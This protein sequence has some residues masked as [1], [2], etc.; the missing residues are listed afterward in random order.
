MQHLYTHV[1][2]H[3]Q[4]MHPNVL[5]AITHTRTHTHYSLHT[6]PPTLLGWVFVATVPMAPSAGSTFRKMTAPFTA[7]L[8]LAI[9]QRRIALLMN[10][11]CPRCAWCVYGVVGVDVCGCGCRVARV[12]GWPQ[13]WMICHTMQNIMLP[14]A[15]R[16]SQKKT[17]LMRPLRFPPLH[18]HHHHP[19]PP[20]NT[21]F[22]LSKN[23][24]G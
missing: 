13:A 16:W 4:R 18:H 2:M 15:H 5:C 6:A 9:T 12:H 21:T 14:C 20:T 11:P 17:F 8:C 1:H 7:P 24:T 19:I 10:K 3:T 23:Q 22:P